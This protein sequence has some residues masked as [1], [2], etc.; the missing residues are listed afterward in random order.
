MVHIRCCSLLASA[1][2]I[3]ASAKKEWVPLSDCQ[4]LDAT[5]NDGDSFRVR[6]CDKEFTARLYYV[7]AP[8]NI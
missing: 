7:D 2:K 4:Y 8:E 5:D 6:A 3:Y 1:A